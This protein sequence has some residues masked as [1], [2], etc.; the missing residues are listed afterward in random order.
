MHMTANR[1]VLLNPEEVYLGQLLV[2]AAR[3][4]AETDPTLWN[5]LGESFAR[6]ARAGEGPRL[7]ELLPA[8]FADVFA[9]PPFLAHGDPAPCSNPG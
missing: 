3:A 1:L 6:T 8:A 9:P 5:A 2:R 4:L 7:A